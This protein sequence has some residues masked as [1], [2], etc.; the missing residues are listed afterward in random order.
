MAAVGQ[1]PP[2]A[3]FHNSAALTTNIAAQAMENTA[4]AAA[5]TMQMSTAVAATAFRESSNVAA[6]AMAAPIQIMGSL[7]GTALPPPVS[8]SPAPYL[9]STGTSIPLPVL[10]A[11]FQA[12]SYRII[13][14]T[15]SDPTG[16]SFR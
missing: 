1:A 5:Q 12:P 10:I 13:P 14:A 8:R 11:A 2:T 15:K 6:A 4:T 7:L 3:L 9:Q 16:D